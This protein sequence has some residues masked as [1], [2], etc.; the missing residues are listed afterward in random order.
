MEHDHSHHHH[1]AELSSVTRSFWIGIILN[2]AFVVIEFTAGLFTNSLAL[3]SD[4][5]HNLSDVAG[6]GLSLFAY[7]ISKSKATGKFTY[8]FNKSTILASLINSVVLLIVVGSIGWEAIHRFM[9][10]QETKGSIVALIAGLGIVINSLSALLFFREKDK[11]LNIK[12]AYLHLAIDALVS[13]TVVIAGLFIVYTGLKWIDPLISLVIM[14]VVVY[15]TWGLLKESLYLTLD[16]VPESVDIEKIRGELLKM[17]EIKD[18]HHIHIWAISTT[19]NAM[20][21]H[22]VLDDSYNEKQIIEVKHKVRH[23]L[24]Y[25][26]IQ[27]ITLETESQSCSNEGCVG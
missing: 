26:N 15:S 13:V 11:D 19:K 2:S 17:S 24:E 1:S 14:V 8:G 9:Q 27:H 10:P 7:K 6:L 4:A 3:L 22:L 21:A 12:A 5:G 20:T 25:F 23:K 16:A 18:I